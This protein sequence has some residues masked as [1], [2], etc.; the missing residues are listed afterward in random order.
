MSFFKNL[1]NHL[2]TIVAAVAA[3]NTFKEIGHSQATT[4]TKILEIVA[5]SAAIG[6]SDSNPQVKAISTTIENLVQ[7]IFAPPATVVTPATPVM[8]A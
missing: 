4:L 8:G 1:Q 5:V 7:T 6:E 3:I 2:N